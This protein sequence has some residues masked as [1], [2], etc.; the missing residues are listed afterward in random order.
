VLIKCHAGCTFE[1]VVEA[2]GLRAADLFAPGGDEAGE[3]DS[4]SEGG[5]SER[6]RVYSY[7]DETGE[8]LFEVVRLAGKRFRQRRPDGAGGWVWNLDDVRRVLYRL[9]SVLEAIA[10]GETV[11][12]AEG[13][14][15]VEALAA[16]GL[17]ATCNPGGAG[18]W[19]EEFSETL[20][21]ASRLVVV[22]DRDE[23]GREHARKVAAS[24]RGIGVCDV[25][26]VEA[27]EGKDAADHLAAKFPL[28]AF[29][30]WQVETRALFEEVRVFVRRFVVLDG[31]QA[32]AVA[33]WV[34]HTYV[35][36]ALGITPY[37]AVSSA[38][39][40]SG[41][42]VLLEVL[43]LLVREPWLT[44]STS[45]AVLARKIDAVRPTLLLDESDAAFGG[46]KEYAEALRGVLNTGFKASGIYS[47]CEGNGANL[48]FRDF[49]TFCPKAIAGIGR[50]PDTVADRSI[51]IRLKRKAPHERVER[52]RERMTGAE[53]EP[54]RT[55]LTVW[56]DAHAAELAA[57]EPTPF[58]A[59]LE[60][61]PARAAD[62]WEPLLGIALLAGREVLAQA[63]AAAQALSGRSE[64][65]D[66]SLGEVLLKDIRDLF[67]TRGVD[68]LPSADLLAGLLE[69]EESPWAD[70]RAGKPL[71]VNRLAALLRPYEI[72]PR[73]IRLP[74][75]QTPKG[76][77]REQFEDAFARY[78]P[79]PAEAAT[80][81]HPA[82][83]EDIAVAA[84]DGVAPQRPFV[85]ATDLAD[86]ASTNGCGGV[87]AEQGERE[88]LNAENA[89]NP[90]LDL[91]A[92]SPAAPTEHLLPGD[93]G[94][95]GL[96]RR[97]YLA[98]LLTERERDDL[99]ALHRALRPIVRRWQ[100][101][102]AP[103][104]SELAIPLGGPMPNGTAAADGT[105]RTHPR[106]NLA[107]FLG[108]ASDG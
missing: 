9:P 96:T 51:P 66:G 18:K 102:W 94:F 31:E 77:L 92:D 62:I 53:A 26:V 28:T 6:E 100:G 106:P 49:C 30:P 83:E 33:L 23:P 36:D 40:Q 86:P 84:P 61:L 21:E 74:D 65:S 101:D 25:S 99:A 10:A 38:E 73:T 20:R 97:R 14:K 1:A 54:L 57:L 82:A 3:H 98:G 2:L 78:L 47:R 72:R 85:A 7:V 90:R 24:L 17:V 16:A 46:D 68:R 81:P 15:D 48:T 41:K 63:E 104:G 52:K 89:P 34:L 69:L 45:P 8:L 80:P 13:E 107:S 60:G 12:L 76:Y 39:K 108:Q 32:T 29:V 11:Y 42:T 58:A 79:P 95:E 37:L 22:A 87:A 59:C 103:P 27:A 93:P 4:G 71:T 67:L 105:P 35:P 56:A 75:G 64:V 70:W 44:G 91:V 55:R 50:L 19:R 43:A 88:P 5:S